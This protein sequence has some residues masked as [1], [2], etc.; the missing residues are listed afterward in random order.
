MHLTGVSIGRSCIMIQLQ[1]PHP[2]DQRRR[3]AIIRQAS[4]AVRNVG[5]HFGR[6]TF[7]RGA[8]GAL[9]SPH[10]FGETYIADL[11]IK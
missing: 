6:L 4:A 11:L 9:T 5:R 1:N 3:V 8:F 7:R 2:P 10:S